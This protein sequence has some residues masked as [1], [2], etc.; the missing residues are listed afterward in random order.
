[1]CVRQALTLSIM[2]KAI[3]PYFIPNQQSNGRKVLA[4]H[5]SENNNFFFFSSEGDRRDGTVVTIT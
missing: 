2:I 3:A 5:T 1:M 4:H